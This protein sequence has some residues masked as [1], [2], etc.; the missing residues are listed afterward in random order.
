LIDCSIDSG[1][2]QPFGDELHF[3][4]KLFSESHKAS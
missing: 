3:S 4:E 2:I 1:S